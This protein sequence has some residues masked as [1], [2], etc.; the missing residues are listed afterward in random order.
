MAG[1]ESNDVQQ[2][3]QDAIRRSQEMYRRAQAPP[4]YTGSAFSEPQPSAPPPPPQQESAEPESEPPESNSAAPTA[5]QNPPSFFQALFS[6]SERNLVLGILL[7]LMEEKDSDPA[8]I[9]AMLY[10]LL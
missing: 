1:S 5:D 3:R 6:D 7:L 4:G 8:L 9:F 2:M 10:L